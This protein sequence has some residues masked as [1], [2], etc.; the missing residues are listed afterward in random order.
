M[1]RDCVSAFGKGS[2]NVNNTVRFKNNVW[3]SRGL[4]VIGLGL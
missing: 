3:D 2:A 1:V 4:V